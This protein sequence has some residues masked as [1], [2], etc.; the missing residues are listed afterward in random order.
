MSAHPQLEHRSHHRRFLAAN[1][2][3]VWTHQMI[4]AAVCG[5]GYSREAQYLHAY[6]HRLRQK[7]GDM[8]GLSIKSAPGIGY[9]LCETNDQPSCPEPTDCQTPDDSR[10]L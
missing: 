5:S 3:K 8:A 4:L 6:I 7:L 1:A 10:A 9:L 2:G